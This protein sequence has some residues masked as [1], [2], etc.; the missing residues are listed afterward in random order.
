M[1]NNSNRV[2]PSAD[3]A[4]LTTAQIN[5]LRALSRDPQTFTRLLQLVAS[6]RET[7]R[8]AFQHY[9]HMFV[10]GVQS[11]RLCLDDTIDRLKT[12]TDSA[13]RCLP[14]AE[15]QQELQ[16][17]LLYEHQRLTAFNELAA[18][19][20]NHETNPHLRELFALR[21]LIVRTSEAVEALATQRNQY[22]RLT[23][24]DTIPDTLIGVPD[25]IELLLRLLL[26]NCLHSTPTGEIQFNIGGTAYPLTAHRSEQTTKATFYLEIELIFP[27]VYRHPG[28][29]EALFY[30][31]VT[32]SPGIDKE[33]VAI[34]GLGYVR[35]LLHQ[36]RGTFEIEE[37]ANLPLRWRVT[38]SLD[39]ATSRSLSIV[40]PTAQI[41]APIE[42]KP[43]EPAIDTAAF[44]QLC[45]RLGS[46]MRLKLSELI[47]IFLAYTT[48]FVTETEQAIAQD[49]LNQMRL[50]AHTL[51]SSS[52]DIGALHLAQLARELEQSARAGHVAAASRKAHQLTAELQRVQAELATIRNQ[53]QTS[54]DII[55]TAQ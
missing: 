28:Q 51:K 33:P 13:A 23:I 18:E 21:P 14:S 10:M 46:G 27:E 15:N 12:L 40:S 44:Q 38:L 3:S 20:L 34:F 32:D 52:A 26:L 25:Q 47:G 9:A 11:T 8:A 31:P 41:N 45:Q 35:H 36:M 2:S 50:I 19:L 1:H 5:Q 37:T 42:Q 7:D 24:A 16:A 30:Y 49:D 48:P 43:L 54:I 29:N 53:L 22:I 55:D 17:S 6:I 39:L 4:A